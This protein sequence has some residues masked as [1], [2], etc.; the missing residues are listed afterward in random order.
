MKPGSENLS[1]EIV[2]LVRQGEQM[3]EDGESTD[4]LDL[5]YRALFL[6]PRN[7]RIINDIGVALLLVGRTDEAEEVFRDAV[8][9]APQNQAAVEN[10]IAVTA[11]Q[12]LEH[13]ADRQDLSIVSLDDAAAPDDSFEIVGDELLELLERDARE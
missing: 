13:D 9:V 1:A 4:A 2:R 3:I 11:R 8:E 7:A 12:R 10:L 5:L 6:D